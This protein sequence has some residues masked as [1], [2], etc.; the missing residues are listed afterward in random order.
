MKQNAILIQN[1]NEFGIKKPKGFKL[2]KA[3]IYIRKSIHELK[4]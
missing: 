4:S 1:G 2:K 3:S